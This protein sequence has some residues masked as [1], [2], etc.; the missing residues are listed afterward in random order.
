MLSVETALRSNPDNFPFHFRQIS[1]NCIRPQPFL[2]AG[3]TIAPS[4]PPRILEQFGFLL[5]LNPRRSCSSQP[6]PS[7]IGRGISSRRPENSADW[8]M[9]LSGIVPAK[10]RSNGYPPT[11]QITQRSGFPV[12]GITER[13][14][15]KTLSKSAKIHISTGKNLSLSPFFANL[16]TE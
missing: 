1:S 4:G 10:T 9:P 15:H 13:I 7:F 8:L 3:G 6:K 5:T 12:S 16:R 11:R 14:F 2:R